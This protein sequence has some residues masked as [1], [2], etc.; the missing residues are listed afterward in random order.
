MKEEDLHYQDL[1]VCF[2]CFMGTVDGERNR[3]YNQDYPVNKSFVEVL[4]GAA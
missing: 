1:L 4:T 2:V 3:D